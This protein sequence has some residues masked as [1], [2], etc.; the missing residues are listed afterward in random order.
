M[1]FAGLPPNV[2]PNSV[3]L[4]VFPRIKV[5]GIPLE[6]TVLICTKPNIPKSLVDET[7]PF[8]LEMLQV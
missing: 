7:V 2:L 1:Q 4:Q 6:R 5:K 8:V 3:N